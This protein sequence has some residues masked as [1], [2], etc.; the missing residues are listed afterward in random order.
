LGHFA[1]ISLQGVFDLIKANVAALDPSDFCRDSAFLRMVFD[2]YAYI[3]P[4][5]E[6]ALEKSEL[7]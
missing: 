6:S 7:K 3:K 5:S 4:A 1:L 2:E